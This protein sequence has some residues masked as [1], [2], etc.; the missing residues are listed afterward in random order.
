M[1]L[2][3]TLILGLAG[4]LAFFPVPARAAAP[5][6][7][8]RTAIEE[9]IR[10]L[11]DP[12]LKPEAKARERQARVGAAVSHLFDYLEIGRRAL[13]RHWRSRS[14]P[15]REEFVRLFRALLERTYLPKIALYQG[16]RVRFL[17]EAVDGDRATV[18]TLLI[19]RQGQEIPVA[20]RLNLRNGN[21]LI[22][23]IVVEGVSLVGN[24]RA[25][26]DKIIQ[27]G[28]YQELVARIK[29]KLTV[30]VPPA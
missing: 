9:V 29:Q 14:E 27:R 24:Y 15:E 18:R 19:T 4:A 17:G 12:T 5:M 21:W 3:R 6:A 28:S 10:I 30:P 26:F 22:F 16:E 23:D 11:E 2:P 1:I 20:Y 13:G 8:L 7:Q 25:Q